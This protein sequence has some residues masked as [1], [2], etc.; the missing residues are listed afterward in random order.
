MLGYL[1]YDYK[2]AIDASGRAMQYVQA[3]KTKHDVPIA[4]FYQALTICALLK[5]KS[6][7][8][9]PVF[10]KI[11][12]GNIRRMKKWSKYSQKYRKKREK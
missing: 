11:L 4:V 12:K 10:W 6:H 2:S 9:K 1:F 5:S 8:V 7:L 3:A